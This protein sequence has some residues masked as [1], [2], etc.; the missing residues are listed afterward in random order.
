MC[1]LVLVIEDEKHFFKECHLYDEIRQ[2]TIETL[3]E[4]IE[5]DIGSIFSADNIVESIM[6]IKNMFRTRF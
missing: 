4:A 2:N 6:M 5:K 3:Q 1:E